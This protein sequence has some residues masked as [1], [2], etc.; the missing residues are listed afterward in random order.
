MDLLDSGVAKLKAH[1]EGHDEELLA[2]DDYVVKTGGRDDEWL[3]FPD[4]AAT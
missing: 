1:E 4:V 2:G 3:A